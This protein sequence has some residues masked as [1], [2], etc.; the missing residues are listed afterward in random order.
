M[1]TVEEITSR[2]VA[3]N[4]RRE[5]IDAERAP[6]CAPGARIGCCTYPADLIEGY[7]ALNECIL[8][9]P[10]GL[11]DAAAQAATAAASHSLSVLTDER[12]MCICENVL[13][14]IVYHLIETKQTDA[15]LGALVRNEAFFCVLPQAKTAK[16]VRS[17]LE[18]LS[19]E[20]KDLDVLY[21]VFSIYRGWCES[22][23]R[24]FLGLRLDLKIAILLL[25]RRNYTAALSTLDR[26]QQEV[27][28]LEDKPLLLDIHLVQAKACL[29]VRNLVRMKI[30]LSN[31]KNIASN[32]NTPTY[33]NAEIDLLSGLVCLSEKDYSTAYSY[34]FEAYEGFHM[35]V[36]GTHSVLFPNLA[37][38]KAKAK[39][40]GELTAADTAGP[41]LVSSAAVSLMVGEGELYSC[42]AAIS[43][44]SPVFFSF[45]NLTEYK[46]GAE[47]DK[48]VGDVPAVDA[49][50][51]HYLQYYGML[52]LDLA[53]NGPENAEQMH[54]ESGE[55]PLDVS[56]LARADERKLVQ[57]L[58]YLL[59]TIVITGRN[60][61]MIPLLAAKNKQKFVNHV[62]CKMIQRISACYKNSSLVEFE[63]LLTEY[64]QV[65]LMDPVLQQEIHRLYEAL[66]ERNITRI[67]QPYSNVQIDFVAN[68]LCLPQQKVE[69]KLAEMILDGKLRGTIDQGQA[70]LVIY[71]EEEHETFY[72]DVN[73]TI[74]HMTKVIDTLYEKAQ[75]AI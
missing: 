24:T 34:F 68:K 13:Y 23:K 48:A 18:R 26:L 58:K 17:V 25:L 32:I 60:D 37:R 65:I 47:A 61:E 35:A 27:K 51:S 22:K 16:L 62:E 5:A 9:A 14:V 67:L 64:K 43:D 73:Q 40:L 7:V 20:V 50:S 12:V 45:Y 2:F 8:G 69:K 30:A 31:A 55:E 15:M 28:A 3:L 57:A 63:K 49:C 36:G 11:N 52:N 1:A 29:L 21:K 71:D 42:H 44:I 75:R 41:A 59:L 46:R 10:G 74:G 54:Y 38:S 72:E 6:K 66:L 39:V 33:V 56:V 70:H 4:A 53:A 19:Q